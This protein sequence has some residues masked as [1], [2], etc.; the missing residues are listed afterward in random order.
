[1]LSESKTLKAYVNLIGFSTQEQKLMQQQ[2]EH[3]STM[4]PPISAFFNFLFSD[5][6]LACKILIGDMVYN[7]A[8]GVR[9]STAHR[10]IVDAVVKG[11]RDL[12]EARI[13][14]DV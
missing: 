2:A 8:M 3:G 6:T 4:V 9:D 13:Y 1:M 10:N 12:A 7:A 14:P 5:E 11:V